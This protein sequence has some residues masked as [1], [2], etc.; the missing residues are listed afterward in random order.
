MRSSPTS[1]SPSTSRSTASTPTTSRTWP[2]STPGSTTP[3]STTAVRGS[4]NLMSNPVV[5]V[6]NFNGNYTATIPGY[7]PS[8]AN[9]LQAP[10][11]RRASWSGV[12]N[13][14]SQPQA[15]VVAHYTPT[16]AMAGVRVNNQACMNCHGDRVFSSA[17]RQRRPRRPPR[18]QPRRRRGLHHLPRP[19]QQRRDPARGPRHAAHGLRARHPQL[20]QHAGRASPPAAAA[21]AGGVYYRN[22]S[23][24]STFSIGF[25]GY[26]N[27]CSTCHDPRRPR[28]DRRHAGLLEGLHVLPR[29]SAHGRRARRCRPDRG[30]RLRLGRLRRRQLRDQR[31]PGLRSSAA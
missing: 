31:R 22:G 2:A 9:T 29:R 15:T 7:G 5:V 12:D 6:S 14:N 24:T 3:P 13:G 19:R 30:R 16:G 18:R 25:P 4:V 20:A 8:G 21:I 23:A 11:G 28:P 26:M 27:N 10:F 1:P 17:R